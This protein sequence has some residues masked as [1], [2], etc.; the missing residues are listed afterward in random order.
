MMVA[1]VVHH[2]GQSSRE[3]KWRVNSF[4][5]GP[6]VGADGKPRLK[7]CSVVPAVV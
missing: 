3:T 4:A 7:A 1:A 5:L 2:Y 6:Q